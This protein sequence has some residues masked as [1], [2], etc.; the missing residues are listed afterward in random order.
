MGKYIAND[1]LQSEVICSQRMANNK[2]IQPD[3]DFHLRKPEHSNNF[4]VEICEGYAEKR[5]S[6]RQTCGRLKKDMRTVILK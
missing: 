5:N 3:F 2:T 1:Q 6:E 4:P